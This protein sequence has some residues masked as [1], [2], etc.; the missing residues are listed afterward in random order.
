MKNIVKSQNDLIKS[1][2]VTTLVNYNSM[3]TEVGNTV[4]NPM[5][6]PNSTDLHGNE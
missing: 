6:K 1:Q 2:P 5:T 3:R 4:D